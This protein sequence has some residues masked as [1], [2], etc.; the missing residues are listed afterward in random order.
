MMSFLLDSTLVGSGLVLAL[1]LLQSLGSR[2]L[3]PKWL[4]LAWVLVS[5]RFLLPVPADM[6]GTIRITPPG[7]MLADRLRSPHGEAEGAS[8]AGAEPGAGIDIRLFYARNG[9]LALWATGA[10]VSAGVLLAQALRLRRILLQRHSTDHD[11]LELLESAKTRLGIHSP[12]G[13]IVSEQAGAPMI[14]GWLRPRII[15]PVSFVARLS[16]REI[17]RVLVHELAHFK[18][19][20]VLALWLAAIVRVVHWF[21]PLAYLVVGQLRARQEE[22][23]DA[24]AMNA[25]RESGLAYGQGLLTALRMAGDDRRGISVGAVAAVS[26]FQEMRARLRLLASGRR[27][28][29]LLAAGMLLSIAVSGMVTTTSRASLL[30]GGPESARAALRRTQEWLGYLDRGDFAGSWKS[31]SVDFFQ[32]SVPKQRWIPGVSGIRQSNGA[33]RSRRLRTQVFLPVNPQGVKGPFVV[34]I[35]DSSFEKLPAALEAVTFVLDSDGQWRASAY[36]LRPEPTALG[37]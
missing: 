19:A 36:F 24:R 14:V 22:A 11:L 17:T 2:R 29:S 21:N 12:I 30:P 27:F 8:A 34:S 18:S 4:A 31:A 6:P 33:L 15:L 7:Q 20:D 26:S 10:V 13:L 16:P 32:K 35:F 1:L 3:A 28:S 25:L 9:M 5:L 37:R 23:S